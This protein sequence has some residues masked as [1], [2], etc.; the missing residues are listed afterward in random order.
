MDA[1]LIGLINYRRQRAFETLDEINKLL[2]AKMLFLA[3]NRVYYAGFY[4]VNALALL[5]NFSSSKHHQLIGYFNKNYIHSGKIK[6]D[7]GEILNIAYK[8]RTSVDYHDFVTVTKEEIIGYYNK[9]KDFVKE[10]DNLILNRL[11]G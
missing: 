1:T 10:V 5:D 3:M 7:I 9:M 8:K 2:N 4:I 11:N 6:T